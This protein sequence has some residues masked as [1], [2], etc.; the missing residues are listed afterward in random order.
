M[1][2]VQL[3]R[4]LERHIFLIKY[5]RTKPGKY[6]NNKKTQHNELTLYLLGCTCVHGQTFLL[7]TDF[8][9]LSLVPSRQPCQYWCMLWVKRNVIHKIFVAKCRICHFSEP[10]MEQKHVL[11]CCNNTCNIKW[12]TEIN[13]AGCHL[14][15]RQMCNIYATECAL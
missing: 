1:A 2:F 12:L 13:T 7:I 5:W 4:N 10:C 11:A 6:T 3:T 15:K 9:L 14:Q 8:H